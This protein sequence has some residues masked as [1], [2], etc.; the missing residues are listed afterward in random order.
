MIA[1]DPT[2]GIAVEKTELDVQ[3]EDWHA[4]HGRRRPRCKSQMSTSGAGGL[5]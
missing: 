5:G 1:V 2:I 4:V 3:Y